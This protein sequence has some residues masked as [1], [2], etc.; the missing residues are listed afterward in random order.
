MD[1]QC[2]V[3]QKYWMQYLGFLM[4]KNLFQHKKAPQLWEH[5]SGTSPMAFMLYEGVHIYCHYVFIT[6][7]AT[8]V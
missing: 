6:V 3:E 1:F 8:A 2:M 7:V 5:L 4:Q